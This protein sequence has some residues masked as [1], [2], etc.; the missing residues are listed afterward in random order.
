MLVIK[1]IPLLENLLNFSSK[2]FKVGR[3]TQI[4]NIVDIKLRPNLLS[5]VLSAIPY[6]D[7]RRIR[8]WVFLSI[9]LNGRLVFS[10]LFKEHSA[11]YTLLVHFWLRNSFCNYHQFRKFSKH[12]SP[13]TGDIQSSQIDIF[14][15]RVRVFSLD[16]AE[17]LFVFVTLSEDL[18]SSLFIFS[19]LSS[20]FRWHFCYFYIIKFKL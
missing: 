3:L 18:E 7:I 8:D 16:E 11:D 12:F 15:L 2:Y 10:Q 5:E 14:N 6:I 1:I 13:V 4:I 20:S 9:K 19:F 17:I